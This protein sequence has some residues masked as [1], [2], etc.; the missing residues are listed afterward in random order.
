MEAFIDKCSV[1]VY[2]RQNCSFTRGVITFLLESFIPFV[3]FH[4]Q[5]AA[6][7]D[8]ERVTKTTVPAI[9]LHCRA[10]NGGSQ[11]WIKSSGEFI[12]WAN[13]NRD[14]LTAA[15]H[16]NQ[17]VKTKPNTRVAKGKSKAME[18]FENGI[19]YSQLVIISNFSL[20]FRDNRIFL[21]KFNFCNFK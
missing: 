13:S 5:S 6:D 16:Y 19:Q 15:F 11:E 21:S 2:G 18:Y 20:T 12:N 14:R 8:D 7:I 3:F 9:F 1:K 4:R 17:H 10:K